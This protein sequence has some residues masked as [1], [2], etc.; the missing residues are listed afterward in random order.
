MADPVF[1]T[2]LDEQVRYEKDGKYED[3][4]SWNHRSGKFESWESSS[5]I[6]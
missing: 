4:A 3:M 5:D 1:A 2:E 6:M